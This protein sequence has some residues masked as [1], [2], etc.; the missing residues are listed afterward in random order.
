[1][2][3]VLDLTRHRAAGA[4]AGSLAA[5][6]TLTG[7]EQPASTSVTGP[8]RTAP[9]SVATSVTTTV[10][11]PDGAQS[12]RVR[13]VVDGDTLHLVA[14]GAGPLA[15]GVDERARLLEIDA[16]ETHGQVEC[17]GPEAGDALARLTPVGST[18]RVIADRE[19]HDKYG[20]PLVYV[21]NSGGVFVN[22]ALTRAGDVSSLLVEPNDKYIAVIR[23]AERD[24]RSAHRGQWGAC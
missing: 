14:T 2:V 9:P 10:T 13:S 12:A 6:V 16:P 3:P 20:R 18:V 4:L 24:A 5:M 23:A 22:E 8:P 17:Y 7:C 11:V 15:A 21:W 1:M 19:R